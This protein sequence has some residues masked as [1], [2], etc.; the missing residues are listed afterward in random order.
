MSRGSR[1]LSATLLVV[2]GAALSWQLVHQ[3]VHEPMYQGKPASYWIAHLTRPLDLPPAS[4]LNTNFSSLRLNTGL[5]LGFRPSPE[6]PFEILHFMSAPEATKAL[7]GATADKARAVQC[8]AIVALGNSELADQEAVSLLRKIWNGDDKLLRYL[9]Y[10]SLRNIDPSGMKEIAAPEAIQYPWPGFSYSGWS[11]SG[12]GTMTT[13]GGLP[14]LSLGYIRWTSN[15]LQ[16]AR[17]DSLLFETFRQ[18]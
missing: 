7:L 14:W 16:A 5:S 9:A 4:Q 18:R 1:I 13:S 12:L 10:Q 2:V 15:G 17:D 8:A 6:K 3:S 11:S